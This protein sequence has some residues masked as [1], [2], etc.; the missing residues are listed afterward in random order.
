M[1]APKVTV[2]MS[3]YNG[4]RYLREAIDSILNQC[5]E[6]F[7][8]LIINDAS[9]DNTEEILKNYKDS[10]IKVI[11]NKKNLG[12]TKSLNKGLKI[13]KGEYIARMDS[14]DI[15][16]PKRLEEEVKVLDLDGNIGLVGTYCFVMD[17]E[18]RILSRLSSLSKSIKNGLMS[19]NQFVHSSVMIRKK[20][21]D[22]TGYYREEFKFA[23][24]YDLWLRISESFKIMNIPKYLHKWRFD[25]K[26]IS[27][28]KNEEQSKYAAL[29]LKLAK[30]RRLKGEDSLQ[31]LSLKQRKAFNMI[32]KFKFKPNDVSQNYNYWAGVVILNKGKKSD[33]L[34]LLTQ[35]LAYDFFNYHTWILVLKLLLSCPQIDG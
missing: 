20:C 30:E 35:S 17:E 12:L 19:V 27:F 33:A 24:D 7:E 4:E 21:L 6:D 25:T 15:S 5:F 10:R 11:I 9:A 2:L 23:Q 16:L 1:N 34:K 14:D 3:V 32:D 28:S 26:S 18:G 13:A 29:A 22:A 31:V 8:F